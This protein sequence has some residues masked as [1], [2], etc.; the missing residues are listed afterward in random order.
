MRKFAW[1]A[2]SFCAAVFFALCFLPGRVLPL[3]AVIAGL[4]GVAAYLLARGDAKIAAA[5]AALGVFAGFL[6]DFGFD[7]L[8]LAGARELDGTERQL[9]ATVTDF[10]ETDGRATT[11]EL[12]LDI[13]E[14]WDLRAK[15]YVYDGSADGLRPGDRIRVEA[16][17]SFSGLVGDEQISSYTS[18]GI[19]LF[20]RTATVTEVLESPGAGVTTFHRYLARSI[21]DMIVRLYSGRARAFMLALLT[22]DRT[23]LSADA[24][25][26]S[27]ME[28]AGVTHIV[29]ISGM[30]VS[31][32]AG[33]L[34]SVLGRRKWAVAAVIPVLVLFMAVSGFSPSVVRAVIM[35]VFLLA[36]PWVMGEDDSLTALSAALFILVA[37]NPYAAAGVGLQLSFAAT[38]GIIV[39]SP[40]LRRVMT[41][42]GEKKRG[43]L[44]GLLRWAAGSVSTSL[45]AL[46]LTMPISAYYFKCVSLIAPLS[47]LLILWAVSPAFIIGA[48]SVAAGAVWLPLG[49]VAA[50]YPAIISRGIL[51][52]CRVLAKPFFAAVYMDGPALVWFAA[53]YFAGAAILLSRTGPRRFIILA[54]LSAVSLCGIFILR[55]L[56]VRGAEGYALTLLDVGQGQSAVIASGGY[57]AVIDC[58]SSSGEDAGEICERYVRSLG[59][60]GIDALILTH[61]HSDHAG[62]A[63]RLLSTLRVGAVFVPEPRFE[64]SSLDEEVL[65]AARNAGCRIVYVTDLT[66]FELGMAD[67]TLYPPM[68]SDSENERGLMALVSDGEF[69]ALLTGDAPG[70]LERQLT[71]RYTL[72][73]TECLVVGHH[74]S[75]GSTTEALLDEVT[76]ELALVS[77]GE[78]SYGHPAPETLERLEE[79]GIQ[80][81]RTDESGNITIHSR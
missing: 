70:Y 29:A 51:F 33:F 39:I 77:V 57:T 69:D 60:D 65:E 54:S 12:R 20:A 61:Y 37:A 59:R 62:G 19:F 4:A 13:P 76:P 26:L 9:E 30:H 44:P 22:G 6:W 25:A 36:A 63:V 27:A 49:R 73:D 11:V 55:D 52:A 68:G 81:L 14:A 80:V 47:N 10:P 18:R 42:G 46:A 1:F 40:R 28:R 71:A 24:A 23:E 41:R 48:V 72:P 31:I 2:F 38:L 32:L 7:R 21:K 58:G 15:A 75:A 50:F 34:L 78:N 8:I 74:G 66:R 45:G 5:I 67:I 79:R 53:A 3:A 64:E 56:S 16:L 17:F 35:Q 43:F